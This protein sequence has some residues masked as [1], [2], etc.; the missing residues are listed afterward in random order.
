MWESLDS[1]HL[2][3]IFAGFGLLFVVGLTLA[4]CMSVCGSGLNREEVKEERRKSWHQLCENITIPTL[5]L[6]PT[7]DVSKVSSDSSHVRRYSRIPTN[8]DV[9]DDVRNTQTNQYSSIA[10][11]KEEC[12]SNRANGRSLQR[13]TRV[14][15]TECSEDESV[16]IARG[17]VHP[18]TPQ[19][20]KYAKANGRTVNILQPLK[21]SES[22]R[23]GRLYPNYEKM[24][25]R[26]S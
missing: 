12:D 5:F 7:N 14:D 10:I 15:V 19:R 23:D 6:L 2:S 3:V 24:K 9:T 16:W 1:A 11:E 13:E 18:A 26:P 25:S 17:S 21:Y 20:K 8:D 4:I 22:T